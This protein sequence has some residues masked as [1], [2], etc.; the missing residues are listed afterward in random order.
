MTQ[1]VQNVYFTDDYGNYAGS[2][3]QYYNGLTNLYLS[4]D[5]TVSGTS[6]LNDTNINGTLITNN[7]QING[8]LSGVSQMNINDLRATG[9]SFVDQNGQSD[10]SYIYSQNGHTDLQLNGN[11]NITTANINELTASKLTTGDL[12]INGALTGINQMD[13]RSLNTSMVQF[14]DQNGQSTGFIDSYNGTSNLYLNGNA[15]I[16]TANINELTASKLT[17]GDLQVNGTLTGINQMDLRGLNTSTVQFVDQNGQSTGF[18]DSYNGTSNLYLNG[19][20]II[21]TA[22]INELTASKLTTGDLQVNGTLTGI[23]QMDLRGLN[24]STVQFVDQNG[25]STG[26]ID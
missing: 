13:L 12:Q 25:Q 11:A 26:F 6:N 10:G 16:N 9:L 2:A 7:L 15:I 23:N 24:T 4:G 3:I 20:A 19:N 17:T 5:N 1:T 14:V 8:T 21:N 22:N 18:I